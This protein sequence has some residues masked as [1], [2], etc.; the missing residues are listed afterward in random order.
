MMTR[1]DPR[2]EEPERPEVRV[3]KMPVIAENVNFEDVNPFKLIEDDG[4]AAS[5]CV[6]ES[7]GIVH[8][9]TVD[10][11]APVPESDFSWRRSKRTPVKFASSVVCKCGDVACCDNAVVGNSE[12][13]TSVAVADRRTLPEVKAEDPRAGL[14]DENGPRKAKKNQAARRRTRALVRA[15]EEIMPHRMCTSSLDE[16]V[17]KIDDSAS[18]FYDELVMSISRRKAMPD[19]IENFS[20]FYGI[21]IESVTP[22][23]VSLSSAGTY[24]WADA[25]IEGAGRGSV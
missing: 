5:E 7:E 12:C 13:H 16:Y 23:M 21:D 17:G 25:D 8:D 1:H 22:L 15:A 20:K 9:R 10:L 4:E 2:D 18:R 19:A 11:C 6:A 3:P 14:S 24:G